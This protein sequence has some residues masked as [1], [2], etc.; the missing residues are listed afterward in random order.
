VLATSGAEGY[1]LLY[2]ASA[3]TIF[4]EGFAFANQF[5]AS[6]SRTPLTIA[7]LESFHAP[8]WRSRPGAILQ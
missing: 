3:P 2:A 1:S 6:V 7:P 8:L 4:T 5:L